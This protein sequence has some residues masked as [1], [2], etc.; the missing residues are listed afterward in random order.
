[1][2]QGLGN[3]ENNDGTQVTTTY[4]EVTSGTCETSGFENITDWNECLEAGREITGNPQ[5]KFYHKMPPGGWPK[6]SKKPTGCT[7]YA[8]RSNLDFFANGGNTGQCGDR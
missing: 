2:Q 5:F 3:A 8:T 4:H 1:M 6:R 7:I